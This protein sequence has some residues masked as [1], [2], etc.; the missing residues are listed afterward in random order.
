MPLT[1]AEW[2]SIAIQLVLTGRSQKR[3]G[4]RLTIWRSSETLLDN[5][6]APETALTRFRLS[7]RQR[8]M[9]EG[10]DRL[11]LLRSRTKRK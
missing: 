9:A 6:S 4:D 10:R 2:Q 3:D 8:R 1:Q 5:L 7:E 11:R